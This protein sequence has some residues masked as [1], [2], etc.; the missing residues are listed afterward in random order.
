[1]ECFW[2]ECFKPKTKVILISHRANQMKEEIPFRSDNI[3]SKNK[4]TA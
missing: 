3:Q 2:I 1:M 4:Q